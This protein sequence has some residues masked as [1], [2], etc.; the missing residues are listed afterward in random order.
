MCGRFR[1]WLNTE[2]AKAALVI[3]ESRTKTQ[4]KYDAYAFRNILAGATKV[5]GVMVN[6]SRKLP[7]EEWYKAWVE[8][9][10]E[11]ITFCMELVFGKDL[12]SKQPYEMMKGENQYEKRSHIR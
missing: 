4:G 1:Y 10:D 5:L 2:V 12:H 8:F 6:R 11:F 7:G 3:R 9:L